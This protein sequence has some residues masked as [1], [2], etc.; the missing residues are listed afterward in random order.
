MFDE[1]QEPYCDFVSRSRLYSY[2]LP[3]LPAYRYVWLMEDGADIHNFNIGCLRG[4]LDEGLDFHKANE[5]SVPA[6]PFLILQP[7]M[8]SDAHLRPVS[9]ARANI[10]NGKTLVAMKTRTVEDL[11]PVINAEFFE[12]FIASALMPLSPLNQLICNNKGH[13]TIWCGVAW[14]YGH[15]KMNYT[16]DFSPCMVLQYDERHLGTL[17]PSAGQRRRQESSKIGASSISSLSKDGVLVMTRI[18]SM[19]RLP[20]GVNTDSGLSSAYT[21]TK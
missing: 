7:T 10:L 6:A 8:P 17:N 1:M 3:I 5:L 4:L 16:T 14:H 21:C 19:W 20:S 11:M 13:E 18:F 2:L 12:W 9:G 15:M